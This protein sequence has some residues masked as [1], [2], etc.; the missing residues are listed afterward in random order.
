MK[1]LWQYPPITHYRGYNLLFLNELTNIK[2]LIRTKKRNKRKDMGWE[3]QNLGY[4]TKK[5]GI[6]L[7]NFQGKILKL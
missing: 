6:W 2:Y 4:I 7:Y 1:R 3:N 5:N